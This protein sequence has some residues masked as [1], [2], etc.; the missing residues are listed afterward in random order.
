MPQVVKYGA[1]PTQA[2]KGDGS[3]PSGQN[4]KL[5]GAIVV[6]V[7]AV[8]LVGYIGY[9]TFFKAAPIGISKTDKVAPPPGY[10]DKFPYN[11]QRWQD[12]KMIGGGFPLPPKLGGSP[13]TGAGGG[14]GSGPG[15]GAPGQPGS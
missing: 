9:T 3:S 8:L 11:Q 4:P 6:C 7:I 2:K 12:G 13:P 15:A 14:A 5:M 1:S 10:P